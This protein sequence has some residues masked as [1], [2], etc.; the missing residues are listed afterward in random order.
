M[1]LVRIVVEIVV[2]VV[3]SVVGVCP[4]FRITCATITTVMVIHRKVFY[5]ILQD[6]MCNYKHRNN[7]IPHTLSQHATDY[8]EVAVAIKVGM[9]VRISHAWHS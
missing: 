8:W 1:H 6:H 5:S 2:V 9:V 4:W 7:P 3:V